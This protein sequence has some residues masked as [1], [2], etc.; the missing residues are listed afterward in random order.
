MNMDLD[1]LNR[2]LF[3]AGQNTLSAEDAGEHNTVYRLCKAYYL[4]T[5]LEVLS[6]VEW[7]GGRRRERLVVTG[8]PVI[9]DRRYRFAYDLPAD[10]ARP[11]ELQDNAYF[12]VEDRLILSDEEC[13]ELLYVSNGKILRPVAAVSAGE[14]GDIPEAEY[15]T[16]GPPGTEPDVT[17]WPGEPADI[18]AALP[19]DPAP[20]DDFPDYRAV[21]Y[22]PKLY[23]CIE[24]T[25][26]ARFAMKLSN[27]PELHQ[28]LLQEAMLIKREAVNASRAARAAKTNG[29]PWWTDELG[30]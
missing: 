4:S 3:D 18:L 11:V 30:S 22:E 15:L 23:E 24:K 12:I 7:V 10:C 9:T 14:A 26:A 1:I 21:R 2:A 5:F 20:A 19:A 28:L 8:R 13:A 27:Q 17:L 16:A 6:E 25:L 29:N